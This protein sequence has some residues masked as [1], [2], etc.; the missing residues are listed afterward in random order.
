MQL[1]FLF[2]YLDLHLKKKKRVKKKMGDK[3]TYEMHI[4]YCINW[5][6]VCHQDYF[7]NLL[8]GFPA[9]ASTYFSIQQSKWSS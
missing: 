6:N 7:I 8:I 2:I 4:C 5:N 3:I 9:S 1:G